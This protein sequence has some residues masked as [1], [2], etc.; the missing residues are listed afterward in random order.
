MNTRITS[1]I[2]VL[3]ASSVLACSDGNGGSTNGDAPTCNAAATSLVFGGLDAYD[4]LTVQDGFVY[5]EIPGEG[6]QRC[7]TSGCTSP[8]S[9]VASD[10]FVSSALSGSNVAYTTQIA[11]TDDVT[12]VG[13]IRYANTDGTND[14]SMLG[15]LTFPSYVAISGASTFWAQDS[16]TVDDTPAVINCIGCNGNAA[17]TPW[18]SGLSG[19]TYGMIADGSNVYVLADDPTLTSITLLSCPVS[20]PCFS[21]PRVVITNLDTTMTPQQIA[22]D[23]TNVYVARAS[24]NDVVRIDAS[25][26]VTPI[27]SLS[28]AV[29]AI[30]VDAAAGNLYYGTMS[31]AVGRVTSA[32][33]TDMVTLAC[34]STGIAALAIDDTSVYLL[35]GTSASD[36][37]K[38]AK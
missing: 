6:V 12:I 31:G 20:R 37:L 3:V 35:T 25:G 24:R 28:E 14:Q 22:S 19:G 18:I 27:V 4:A 1:I 10:G 29:T 13:E 11:S 33:G 32:G 15:A 8:T 38:S 7:P 34:S 17:S 26:N 30:A 36:V 16:F 23:G 5:V 2:V 21:E 9:V